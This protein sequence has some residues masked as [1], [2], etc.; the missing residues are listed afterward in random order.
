LYQE[1]SEGNLQ[2]AIDLYRK[3]ITEFPGNREM[4]AKAQLHIGLCYEKMGLKEAEKAYRLVLDNYPDQTALVAVANEKLLRL[5]KARSATEGKDKTF[6]IRKV[7]ST[8]EDNQDVSPDGRYLLCI[9]WNTISLHVHDMQT[10]ETWP[11]SEKGTWEEPMRWPDTSIWHPN[12]RQLAYI[13]YIGGRT[14]LRL[15]NLDGTD[16]RVLSSGDITEVLWPADWSQDGKY[17][18]GALERVIQENPRKIDYDIALLTV[19]DGSVKIIK[20]QDGRHCNSYTLALDNSYVLCDFEHNAD[21]EAMDI[22]K[23]DVETGAET[24]LVN[25]PANDWSPFLS[26]DGDYLVF[27]SDRAGS[28]GLWAQKMKAGRPDGEPILL[29]GDLGHS[30]FLKTLT[31]DGSLMYGLWMQTRNV[32]TAELDFKSGKVISQPEVYVKRFEGKNFMPF[33]SPDGKY[34]AYA[35]WRMTDWRPKNLYVI[36]NLETGEEMDL[37]TDLAI[38]A[39]VQWLKPRWT[40]DSKSLLIHG[41]VTRSRYVDG[42]YLVDIKT[43]KRTWI[44]EK[45][46]EGDGKVGYWPQLAP[47]GN[48][49]Y[50]LKGNR[51]K[52]MKY[53]I[54]SGEKTVLHESEGNIY[55]TAL[56]PDGNSLAFRHNFKTANELWIIPTN[57]G[58]PRLIGSLDKEEKIDWPEWT[59]DSRQ[60]IVIARNSKE[61]YAFS[62]D[63][64]KPIRMDL[65]LDGIKRLSIHPDGKRLAFMHR[66]RRGGDVWVMENFL[67]EVK[68]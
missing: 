21:D 60:V 14:E 29:K 33:W 16:T 6:K 54:S 45:D 36:K 49:L 61:L 52:L 3:V 30:F 32:K 41:R 31:A 20:S 18:L 67:P 27:L 47:D 51:R 59:P 10:G 15:C 26:P 5:E 34:L 13:W 50:Y 37:Q 8:N 66:Q 39:P 58:E 64:G 28:N 1:E 65:R 57:G 55:F 35:S 23:I 22:V 4:A 7:Y 43:G 24:K 17:I 12:S 19:A 62:V 48:I 2:K 9:H 38:G 42:F 40:P 46:A 68:K 44:L 56:S 63:G 53:N 25:H 11:I